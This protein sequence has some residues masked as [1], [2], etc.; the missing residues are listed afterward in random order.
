MQL[1]MIN[2][3]WFGSP[4]EGRPGLEKMKEL[5]FDAVDVLADPLD[6]TAEQRATMAR[7]IAEV[8]LAVPSNIVVAMGFSD[9]NPSIRNFHIERAK[10][11]VD[12]TV[13]LGAR[14]LVV[15]LGEYIWQ[16]EVIPP[17][18]Q[19]HWAV[20]AT[21]QLGDYAAERGIELAMELEPFEMSLVNTIEKLDKLLVDVDHP[22][23][24]AN[25]DCSHLWLMGLDASEILKLKG[26][27]IHT[28][29]SDCNGE[30]H[31]D[32]PPGRGN[33]PLIKYLEALSEAD[34]DGVISLELEY[35]P[36]L[37]QIVPWVTEAYE[38]TAAMMDRVGVRTPAAAA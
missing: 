27:I 33:T 14:I 10:R 28:H 7:D 2:S 34:F 15:A 11:H 38:A 3:A 26:R 20:D 19:W 17:E 36:Q 12:L 9:W 37:D 21:R 35:A 16:H 4:Y 18:A 13:E 6:L 22:A 23:V 1:G 30:T 25:I 24:K 32:L 29:F 8:G 31:G 5:G